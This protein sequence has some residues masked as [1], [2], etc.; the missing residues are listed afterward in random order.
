M[1]HVACCGLC[2]SHAN[3]QNNYMKRQFSES[4]S[5]VARFFLPLF[6]LCF[7][8]QATAAEAGA[9]AVGA[10]AGAAPYKRQAQS[11]LQNDENEFSLQTKLKVSALAGWRERQ[12]GLATMQKSEKI[13]HQIQR[14][15]KLFFTSALQPTQPP[16]QPNPATRPLPAALAGCCRLHMEPCGHVVVWISVN[17]WLA[18]YVWMSPTDSKP[19]PSTSPL[20]AYSYIFML[21]KLQ[22]FFIGAKALTKCS[23][24]STVPVPVSGRALLHAALPLPHPL[25]HSFSPFQ[26]SL[27][28][29]K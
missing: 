22:L 16:R 15:A 2:G 4:I 3:D 14:C 12:R 23:N 21:C 9:A 27:L 20:T 19:P 10:G 26:L 24:A 18:R 25:S 13:A 6:Y 5:L 28:G 11:Q 8:L 7:S 1:L 29:A 17:L